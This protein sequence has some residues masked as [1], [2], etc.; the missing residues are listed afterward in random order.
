[1][2]VTVSWCTGTFGSSWKRSRSGCPT[3]AARAGRLRPGRGAAGRCGSRAC[4]PARRRRRLSSAPWRRRT[5]RSRRRGSGRAGA[6]L[7]FI[8]HV[9][10]PL[11][12]RRA[13]ST[14]H[15][16][17]GMIPGARPR[18]PAAAGRARRSSPRRSATCRRRADRAA[19]M[20]IPTIATISG[21]PVAAKRARLSVRR[22]PSSR[23]QS[24]GGP[25]TTRRAPGRAPRAQGRWAS[26]GCRG[27]SSS[28]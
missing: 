20:P 6:H 5:R 9:A 23:S 27:R 4:R 8:R 1:M 26:A 10:P 18:S 17:G 2:P 21:R 19:S 22:G 7:A 25:R 3:A 24:S 14:Q 28:P 12:P 16:P 11:Q 15:H 13:R